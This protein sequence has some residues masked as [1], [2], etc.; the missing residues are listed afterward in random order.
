MVPVHLRL[1]NNIVVVEAGSAPEGAEVKEA[2]IW[3]ALV[4]R[5][6]EV[7]IKRGENSGKTLTYYNVV[8][9]MTP[10]GV[11]NGKPLTLQLA[12]VAVLRPETENSVVLIQEGDTGAIIGSAWLGE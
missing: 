11:W 2:T 10:V 3:L 1:Y 8:R 4:E 5:S 7:P 12:R 6:S 9:S